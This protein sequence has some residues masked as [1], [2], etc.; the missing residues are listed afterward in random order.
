[1]TW[2][3]VDV[4]ACPTQ[5]LTAREGIIESPNYPDTLLP[6]LDCSIVIQAP[7]GK[8]IWLEFE[9]VDLVD[10]EPVNNHDVTFELQLGKKS[11]NFRPFHQNNLLTEGKWRYYR[12]LHVGRK[13][14]VRLEPISGWLS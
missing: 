1:M 5:T 8:R 12:D 14:S 6:H 10:L 2:T 7:P 4:S 9:D 11:E 3:A 13:F